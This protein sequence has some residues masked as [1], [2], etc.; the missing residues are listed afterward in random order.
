MSGRLLTSHWVQT[1]DA[2]GHKLARPIF[3]G[4]TYTNPKRAAAKSDREYRRAKRRAY[5]KANK[6]CRGP[7]AGRLFRITV[8]P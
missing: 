1:V 5:A 8:S 6:P 3:H 7:R 2:N 4:V